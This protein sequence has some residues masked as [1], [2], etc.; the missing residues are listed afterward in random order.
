M[1]KDRD[2]AGAG[3]VTVVVELVFVCT[4]R[5]NHEEV[6]GLTVRSFHADDFVSRLDCCS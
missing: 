6:G 3:W 5:A 1:A 2:A 4:P